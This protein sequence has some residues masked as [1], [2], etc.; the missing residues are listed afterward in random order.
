MALKWRMKK[1]LIL[2]IRNMIR[3]MLTEDIEIW[4]FDYGVLIVKDEKKR[5]WYET[6]TWDVYIDG[7][8]AEAFSSHEK[9]FEWCCEQKKSN[10]DRGR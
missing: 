3:T 7:D 9:A 4:E 1:I 6:E 8:I 2:K 5:P 10:Y